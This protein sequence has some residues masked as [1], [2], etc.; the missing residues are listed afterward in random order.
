MLYAPD[1]FCLLGV[2]LCFTDKLNNRKRKE[3]QQQKYNEKRRKVL[4]AQQTQLTMKMR[5][6]TS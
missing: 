1:G 5:I 6:C 4:P 3:K 2:L